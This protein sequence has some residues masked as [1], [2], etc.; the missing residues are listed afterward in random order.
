MGC[1]FCEDS[2]TVGRWYGV[3]HFEEELASIVELDRY[4]TDTK[5]IPPYINKNLYLMTRM[6]SQRFLI[7]LIYN[8]LMIFFTNLG[9]NTLDQ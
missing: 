9:G 8:N 4:F 3:D 2:H 6:Q 7:I 5:D 1:K